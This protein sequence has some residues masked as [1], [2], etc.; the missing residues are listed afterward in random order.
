MR[1]TFFLFIFLCLLR[2]GLASKP[3]CGLRLPWE[4]DLTITEKM[5]AGGLKGF[6]SSFREES[7]ERKQYVVK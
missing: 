4:L 3:Y 1:F 2:I 5:K 7:V 6:M